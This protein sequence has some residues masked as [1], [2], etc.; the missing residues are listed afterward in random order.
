MQYLTYLALIGATQAK[1]TLVIDDAKIVGTAQHIQQSVIA[2]A[3]KP[4]AIA[5]AQAV[6]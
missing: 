4:E 2:E 6:E 5:V 1:T 3:T